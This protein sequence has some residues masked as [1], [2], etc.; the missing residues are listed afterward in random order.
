MRKLILDS[1]SLP[2]KLNLK[3]A[4]SKTFDSGFVALRYLKQ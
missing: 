3:L 1:I 2:E 4:E